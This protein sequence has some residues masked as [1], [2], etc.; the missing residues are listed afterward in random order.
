MIGATKYI[1]GTT[2]VGMTF[3]CEAFT[4]VV[5][6]IVPSTSTFASTK[7]PPTENSALLNSVINA[8]LVATTDAL[9]AT[10]VAPA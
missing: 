8:G 7:I 3:L 6:P 1:L 10:A 9:S 4:F 5:V 2:A